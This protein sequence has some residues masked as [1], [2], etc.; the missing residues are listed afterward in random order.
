MSTLGT[1]IEIGRNA[2][3]AHQIGIAVTGDNIANVNTPGFSRKRAQLSTTP[4][5]GGFGTG[6]Q[7]AEVTRARDQLIDAQVRFENGL[8][9]RLESMQRSFTTIE[10]V[11]SELAGSSAGEAGAV[12]S[13]SSGVGLSG[14][15]SRFFNGFQDLA[16]N[17]ESGSARSVIR[18]EGQLL[19]R[20]FN[21]LDRQL[22][23]LRTELEA[24][25]QRKVEEANTL[26]EEIARLNVRI[27]SERLAGGGSGGGLE[28]T[29]DNLVDELSKLID[30]TIRE[31]PSG[32][33]KV[34]GGGRISLVD[35]ATV[36]SLGRRV[37]V[38]GE[39]AVS[40]LTLASTG[41]TITLSG[42]VLK[43]IEEIRD[44]RVPEYLASLDTLAATLVSEVNLKHSA[45]FGLNG[46]SGTEFFTQTGT[47]ALT[48]EVNS[49]IID[50][51][52]LI[53]ASANLTFGNNQ[54]A[55][56]I[57]DIRLS[58]L[59]NG[60]TKTA[61]EFYSDLIGQIGSQAKETF[62]NLETQR[63]ISDQLSN[64]RENIRGVSINEEA[65]NLILFQ[66]AYQA[67]A[68]II[69]IV[70]EMFQS[71]LEI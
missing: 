4:P 47:T 11:F 70:D 67:A 25:F 43:G 71:V 44:T 37:E 69:T 32:F 10:A 27:P 33:I 35:N 64:R 3:K 1:S 14:S 15:M 17:P 60:G 48:I 7:V 16:N 56:D 54:V 55:L 66:R 31:D 19:T 68:R 39:A 28:D 49:A 24:E 50:N 5:V 29:R 61:E 46:V 6:V 52:D 62:T 63:V 23:D 8:F 38:V 41:E 45:G 34:L 51:T 40:K 30:I 22:R 18:E 36:N 42:G 26:L 58:Q 57:A 20:T 12:F 21:R 9:G 65:A 59:F 53:A 2:L 13:Q